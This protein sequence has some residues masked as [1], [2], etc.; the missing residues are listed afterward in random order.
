MSIFF[1]CVQKYISTFFQLQVVLVRVV[2]GTGGTLVRVVRWYVYD[3]GTVVRST[4]YTVGTCTLVRVVRW[5]VYDRGTVKCQ[6][7]FP[8]VHINLV[9]AVWLVRWYVGTC[10]LVR[11]RPWYGG[12][13]HKLYCGYMYVGTGGTLVRIRPWYGK[14][15]IFFSAGTYQPCSSCMVGTLVRWYMYVGT[16]TTVVRPYLPTV[17]KTLHGCVKQ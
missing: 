4:N 1:P 7:F 9:P 10:T 8:P 3:R 13:V 11:I 2:R 17:N 5:Y 16:Y 15:S 12:T 14:V 6:Y